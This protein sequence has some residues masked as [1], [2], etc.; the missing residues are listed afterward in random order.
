VTRPPSPERAHAAAQLARARR[1]ARVRPFAVT[2]GRTGAHLHL[3]AE[4][5]VTAAHRDP[6]LAH[7]LG[8]QEFAVYA[9]CGEC[10]SIAEIAATTDLSIGVVRVLVSDLARD[11]YVL[12]HKSA[13]ESPQQALYERVLNGLNRL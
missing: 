13:A 2:G 3:G 6:Q 8:P 12:I 1:P 10:R 4:R 7:V 9:A 11:R 5:L